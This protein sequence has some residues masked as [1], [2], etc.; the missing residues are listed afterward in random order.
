[1]RQQNK[2]PD[3]HDHD[4]KSVH[5]SAQEKI[6]KTQRIF[7]KFLKNPKIFENY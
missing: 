4:F 3:S 6:S 1:M 2:S 5:D 7:K